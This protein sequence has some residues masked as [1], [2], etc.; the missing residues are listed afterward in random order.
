MAQQT[1]A[2]TT[3]DEQSETAEAA[4]R[5]YET[6][7]AAVD[8]LEETRVEDLKVLPMEDAQRFRNVLDETARVRQAIEN[9]KDVHAEGDD[10]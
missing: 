5:V 10:R 1:D 3:D 8:A 2:D 9:T 7:D 4:R 6:L